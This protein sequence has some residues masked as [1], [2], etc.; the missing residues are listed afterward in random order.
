VF[1]LNLPGVGAIE[2]IR[3]FYS[4]WS[5]ILKSIWF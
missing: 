2:K 5:Y 1:E 3:Y 4:I